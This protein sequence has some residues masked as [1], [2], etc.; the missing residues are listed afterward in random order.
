[1]AFQWQ[2]QKHLLLI[3]LLIKQNIQLI[4]ELKS[5]TTQQERTTH[6]HNNVDDV[7]KL[8]MLTRQKE[9]LNVELSECNLNLSLDIHELNIKRHE[10]KDIMFIFLHSL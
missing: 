6:L 8:K 9:V 2:K 4:N 3:I 1:M 5:Q 7:I 10:N